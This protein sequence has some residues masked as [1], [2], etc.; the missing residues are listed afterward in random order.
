MY[1]EV[2]Q[3][4]AAFEYNLKIIG[5]RD[6]EIGYL[7]MII[8]E[9][10]AIILNQ[11]THYE[12]Y[13][14][15]ILRHQE[16]LEFELNEEVKQEHHKYSLVSAE[17]SE[18]EVR[19]FKAERE[20]S[21]LNNK[22]DL[23]RLKISHQAKIIEKFTAKH[24][25]MTGLLEKYKNQIQVYRDLCEENREEGEESSKDFQP[26]EMDE[27]EILK[28]EI[29]EEYDNANT[30][31]IGNSGNKEDFDL[32]NQEYHDCV[33]LNGTREVK[34]REENEGEGDVNEEEE[35]EEQQQQQQQ[36]E[37]QEQDHKQEEKVEQRDIKTEICEKEGEE[38]EGGEERN[39]ESRKLLNLRKHVQFFENDASIPDDDTKE[40]IKE[41]DESR[42]DLSKEQVKKS[43]S[44]IRGI[45]SICQRSA[46]LDG[47]ESEPNL[48]RLSSTSDGINCKNGKRLSESNLTIGGPQFWNEIDYRKNMSK[49]KFRINKENQDKENEGETVHFCLL[50]EKFDKGIQVQL[51]KYPKYVG[52]TLKDEIPV[53]LKNNGSKIN[54][55]DNKCHAESFA[56]KFATEN[57]TSSHE[58]KKVEIEEQ[59]VSHEQFGKNLQEI[60]DDNEVLRKQNMILRNIILDMKTRTNHNEKIET[61][62]QIDN[63]MC[64]QTKNKSSSENNAHYLEDNDERVEDTVE[65]RSETK[66]NEAKDFEFL[67]NEVDHFIENIYNRNVP[68]EDSNNS[69]D[70]AT[71]DIEYSEEDFP[72]KQLQRD[73]TCNKSRIGIV[74]P[75]NLNEN[76]IKG[77][78][79]SEKSFQTIK[80]IE[81]EDEEEKDFQKFFH[82]HKSQLENLLNN[83]ETFPFDKTKRNVD[84]IRKYNG[85]TEMPR[86]EYGKEMPGKEHGNQTKDLQAVRTNN[87]GQRR[88]KE[89][90]ALRDIANKFQDKDKIVFDKG[91]KNVSTLSN[92]N[93]G[94]DV[95]RKNLVHNFQA[96][97]ENLNRLDAKGGAEIELKR[98]QSILT[99]L[100]AVREMR[101]DLILLK[102]KSRQSAKPGPPRDA[103][104]GSNCLGAPSILSRAKAVA[105][106]DSNS[107]GAPS[108]LS[109]AK[110]VAHGTYGSGARPCHGGAASRTPGS[111]HFKASSIPGGTEAVVPA[112]YPYPREAIVDGGPIAAAGHSSFG[113]EASRDPTWPELNSLVVQG[114]ACYR[115]WSRGPRSNLSPIFQTVHHN[116]RY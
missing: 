38:K 40:V 58:T 43:E 6:E 77:A 108:I 96:L 78:L 105:P 104:P 22:L 13:L 59:L 29:L 2:N 31:T 3:L 66:E 42:F 64:S 54:L 27:G 115:P 85:R 62:K 112:I 53:K 45:E 91:K 51:E 50:S 107:L 71:H 95:T 102:K 25:T 49:V 36:Q 65:L 89:G 68:E 81:Q 37:E 24:K 90:K 28:E 30:Y 92:N 57:K 72:V 98:S 17:L 73:N 109:R 111:S 61:L 67:H 75:E 52:G 46:R 106:G 21:N 33:M 11:R 110:A 84:D 114:S 63:E 55:V 56:N 100:S 88:R 39:V 83:A 20:I 4:M 76:D 5:E 94:M 15:Q 80:S 82:E 101:H 7:E 14:D 86:K 60:I 32:G 116:D 69:Y 47:C 44:L 99:L 79:G 74:L 8:K 23:S 97:K 26:D 48:K 19:C 9:Q 41:S 103:A 35:E 18:K 34:G 1:S 70:E 10:D 93:N 16:H 12:T 113:V 87:S